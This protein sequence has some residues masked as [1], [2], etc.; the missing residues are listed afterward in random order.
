[1]NGEPG[2][3]Y[4]AASYLYSVGE[5][6]AQLAIDIAKVPIIGEYLAAPF[7]WVDWFLYWVAYWL[8]EADT[9]I[10]SLSVEVFIENFKMWVMTHLGAAPWDFVIFQDDLFAFCLHRMGLPEYQ[11]LMASYDLLSYLRWRI[12]VWWGFL[13]GIAED[14]ANWIKDQII[15]RWPYVDAL[16]FKWDLIGY[17][18]FKLRNEWPAFSDLLDDPARW[19]WDWFEEAVDQ[20]IDQRI[21]WLIYTAS[22]VINLIWQT[23]M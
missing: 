13:D 6:F 18:K 14:A 2:P 4:N 23:R 22:R 17:V 21:E 15:D 11:A 12:I 1:V 5:V 16:V 8:A 7:T 3:L 9:W 19:V 10:G 20:F